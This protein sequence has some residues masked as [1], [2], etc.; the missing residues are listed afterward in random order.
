[1]F[2]FLR[3]KPK[4]KV[5]ETCLVGSR[6]K[7]QDNCSGSQCK[8]IRQLWCC[9]FPPVDH[10]CAVWRET[11]QLCQSD[12]RTLA[13][14]C[15]LWLRQPPLGTGEKL[16]AIILIVYDR[17]EMREKEDACHTTNVS[18]KQYDLEK[19][20]NNNCI[21]IDSLCSNYFELGAVHLVSS[22][23]GMPTS[24]GCCFWN[25]NLNTCLEVSHKKPP[26]N[27]FLIIPPFPKRL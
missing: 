9:L 13:V 12:H 3:T 23:L 5:M 2:C 15:I 18:K 7:G 16:F 11:V 6:D 4:C 10:H 1:M 21:F 25:K 27:L 17:Q 24:T 22:S 8:V 14:V 20:L 26:N 19:I